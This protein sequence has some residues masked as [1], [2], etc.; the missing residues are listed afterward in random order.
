MVKRK[1]GDYEV[2]K[3]KILPW[4]MLFLGVIGCNRQDRLVSL[5]EEAN[6]KTVMISVMSL[7]EVMSIDI[8]GNGYTV[9]KATQT[10]EI[11]GSGVLVSPNGHVLSVAH[12]F[13]EGQILDTTVC[14]YDGYCMKG[15]LL[16]KEDEHDLSL[17]KIYTDTPEYARVADPRNVK[18]GQEVFAIGFPMGEFD[19]TV[20]HGIISALHRDVQF[21]DMNQSDTFI[22][23]GNSGG[24]LFNYN[25][26]LVGINSLV[27][28]SS[29]FSSGFTGIGMSCSSGQIREFLT[30][31][32]NKVKGL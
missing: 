18:V 15:E 12:L 6:P 11:R 19:W 27:Y 13:N 30:R 1:K 17:L 31:F 14:M 23:P 20:T 21:Y 26:E 4:I 8:S 24:P 2:N 32:R 28:T 22:N 5:S 10:V 3:L 7:M 29:E 9:N 25:G 16:Y